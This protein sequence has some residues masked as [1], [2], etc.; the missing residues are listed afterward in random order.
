MPQ[1]AEDPFRLICAI[2]AIC[3]LVDLTPTPDPRQ[4]SD[5][6]RKRNTQPTTLLTSIEE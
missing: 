3:G 5:S 2:C 1:I 6:R 4:S